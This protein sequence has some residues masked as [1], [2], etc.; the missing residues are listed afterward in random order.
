[1]CAALALLID[2]FNCKSFNVFL[3]VGIKYLD[4]PSSAK[5]SSNSYIKATVKPV[6][7]VAL[8][9]VFKELNVNLKKV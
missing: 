4:F 5:I 6:P 7:T 9:I 8:L 1:V 3:I 2:S